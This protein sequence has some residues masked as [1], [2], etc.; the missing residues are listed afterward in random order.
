MTRPTTLARSRLASSPDPP[1]A[2]DRHKAWA[3]AAGGLAITWLAAGTTAAVVLAAGA[4]VWA[5]QSRVRS[6]LDTRRQR[7]TQLP[8]ALD[9]LS[10]SLRSGASLPSAIAEAAAATP[11]PLGAEL[12][13]LAQAADRGRPLVEVLDEW[14][15]R[16]ADR[17]TRLAATA[18]VL[19][20][21]V[22]SAPARA[23]DGVAATLRERLDL[24]A[25]RRALSTQARTSALVLALA[26]LAFALVLLAGDK[27]AGDFL[28]GHPTGWACLTIGAILDATGAWWMARLTKGEE[29]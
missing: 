16:E 25:E 6:T 21:V 13:A 19:A 26:P 27:A 5:A 14:S 10:T 20:S 23:V 15:A 3:L 28:L 2:R 29:P 8:A 12:A 7:A 11:P 1:G 18:L 4:T 17:G 9:R 24:T 22:G